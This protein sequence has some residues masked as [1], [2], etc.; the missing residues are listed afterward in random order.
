MKGNFLKN[1]SPWGMVMLHYW[2][3]HCSGPSVILWMGRESMWSVRVHSSQLE[4]KAISSELMSD[5]MT[6]GNI[7][8]ERMRKESLQ[9]WSHKTQHLTQRTDGKSSHLCLCNRLW[10]EESLTRFL[11]GSASLW[12]DSLSS[13]EKQNCTSFYSQ[14]EKEPFRMRGKVRHF[15]EGVVFVTIT[16]KF[17]F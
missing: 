17:C 2:S 5:L 13:A 16:C 10:R 3:A 9:S 14:W 11:S 12:S 4:R 8:S 7:T 6:A 15:N 1:A